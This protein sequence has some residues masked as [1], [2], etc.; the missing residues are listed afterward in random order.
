MCVCCLCQT[1][2]QEAVRQQEEQLLEAKSVP[3]RS[4]LTEHVMPTLTQGLIEC[5]RARPA[6]PVDFLVPRSPP[7]DTYM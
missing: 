6:D 4:Y 3:M 2:R 5:C 7:A 1:K